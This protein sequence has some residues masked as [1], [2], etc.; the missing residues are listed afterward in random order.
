MAI[1]DKYRD[2]LS[3]NEYELINWIVSS[4]LM[5]EK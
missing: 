4:L 5:D 1:I 3:D 2:N